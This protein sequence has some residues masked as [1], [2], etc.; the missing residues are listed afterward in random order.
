MGTFRRIRI[1]GKHHHIELF[2]T[3]LG[4][5][6]LVLLINS[7]SICVYASRENDRLLSENAIFANSFTTSLS[8]KDGRISQIYVNP[9]RN[10]CVVLFQ[11]NDMNGMVTDAEKYQ[12]FIKSFDVFKGDYAS[13][14]TTQLDVMGGF[15]VFGSTGYTALY[16][17]AVNGFPKECYEIILRCNDVLQIGTNSSDNENAARDASYAQ[18]DQWRVIINPNGNTAKECSFLDDFNITS[19]YQ[20]AV[21]DENEG[22]IREKLYEDVKI[23]YSSWK[24]LNNYRNNLENLNVKVPS[25][26]VYI[27][28]DELTV[29]EDGIIQYHS[30]FE[31]EDGVDYDWYGKTLHEVSFLDMVKQADITDVQF[32]NSL[33]N[34]QTSDFQLTSNIWYMADG[35]VINLDESN[36]KLTNTQAVVENIKS[37][38]QAVNDYYNAKRQYHCT[39][40]IDY[41]YLESNMKTAGKY[42][43]SNYNEGVVTVW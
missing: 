23:M 39:H 11:F 35:S 38:N 14:R 24:K 34:Y 37:Y 30:G 2:G 28:S 10:K 13:R 17:S 43:T 32:F 26:P 42:F 21:I 15:Y 40:L 31:L 1:W 5:L 20:D 12:V 33:N 19:L 18:F 27:A 22:E 25:L 8:G 16:L 9:E 6:L 41:L 7:I 29:D 36:L 4:M 3:I